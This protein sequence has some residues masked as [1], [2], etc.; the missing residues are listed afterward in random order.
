MLIIFAPCPLTL[1]ELAV[2]K[3]RNN[4][5]LLEAQDMANRLREEANTAQNK[6][7]LVSLM[8]SEGRGQGKQGGWAPWGPTA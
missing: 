6:Y 1:Q 2:F 3:S 4:V 5:A 7:D 8:G